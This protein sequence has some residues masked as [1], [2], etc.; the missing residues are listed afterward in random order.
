V[1]GVE[2]HPACAPFAFLI[3]RWEGEGRGLWAADPPFTYREEVVFDHSGKPFIRYAQRTW[4]ADDGRPMHA[5]TGY[6]RPAPG[7]RVELVIAQPTGIVEV[8]AGRLDGHAVDL[9]PAAVMVTPT[10]KNVTGISRGLRVDDDGSLRYLVRIGVN[11]EP[12]AD[13]L[14]ATLRR[15][16]GG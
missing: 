3:G 15:T 7:G 2:L 8:H 6:L 12:L 10:A 13:H 4:A 16:D 5:E 11:G 9:E 1:G 14:Q